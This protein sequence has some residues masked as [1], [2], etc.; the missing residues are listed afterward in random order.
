MLSLYYYEI[1]TFWDLAWITNVNYELNYALAKSLKSK[2]L[3]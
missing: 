3:Y 1:I 2:L